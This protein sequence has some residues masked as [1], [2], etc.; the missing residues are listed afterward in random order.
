MGYIKYSK[1]FIN[2]ITSKIDP[3]LV[4]FHTNK[5]IKMKAFDK[6]LNIFVERVLVEDLDTTDKN[7]LRKI[8]TSKRKLYAKKKA[9]YYKSCSDM[10]DTGEWKNESDTYFFR[11]ALTVYNMTGQLF[12]N[13][14]EYPD[15][16]S[17]EK[18]QLEIIKKW[19]M[20]N[21]SKMI[22]FPGQGKKTPKAQERDFMLDLVINVLKIAE[23]EYGF[24][25]SYDVYVGVDDIS[26]DSLFVNKKQFVKKEDLQN[27]KLEVYRS[28]DGKHRTIVTFPPDMFKKNK[29]V[30]LFD[31]KD[32]QILSY[33]ILQ[34]ENSNSSVLP[35]P[36]RIIDIYHA[37]NGN[38]KLKPSANQ[39]EEIWNRCYKMWAM[40]F[41]GYTGDKFTGGRRLIAECEL[42]EKQKII[43][44]V[45]SQYLT[46]Q[47]KENRIRKMP[48]DDLN[49]LEENTSKILYYPFMKQRVSAYETA[50]EKGLDVPSYVM[51]IRYESF[52]RWV[53][54]GDG[55]K[56]DN[57]AQI[58]SALD[59]FKE[60]EIFVKNYKYMAAKHTYCIE[61]YTLSEV[62]IQ[63]LDFYFNRQKE[64]P[65]E[66]INQ[67]NIFTPLID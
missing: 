25:L 2:K 37:I 6:P 49:R 36:I 58:I 30:T 26:A 4:E 11:D 57:N 40:G 63:D 8:A 52:L 55:N 29:T 45:M 22:D 61:F 46:D 28:E 47:I 20:D 33:L 59:E 14:K 9:R 44:V 34:W 53:N 21:E 16:P 42:D 13:G 23:E 5:R 35:L 54:F 19:S 38:I 51:N 62:E 18:E 32:M 27:G 17:M 15:F 67:L 3:D 50:L 31:S 41:E 7:E 56:K 39:Y 10:V 48:A 64:D 24:D 12:L 1:S 60:K 66:V 65:E 43:Y